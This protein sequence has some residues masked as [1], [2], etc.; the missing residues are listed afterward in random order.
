MSAKPTFYIMNEFLLPTPYNHR[1]FVEKFAR[2]FLYNG[3]NIK[4]VNNISRLDSPGFVMISNHPFYHR[5]ATRLYYSSSLSRVS[6]HQMSSFEDKFKATILL[7]H[8][9]IR[10]LAKRIRD[11]KIVLLAWLRYKE[12]DFFNDLGI[13]I[14]FT[15]EHHYGRPMHNRVIAWYDY[16]STKKNALPVEFAADVDPLQ[17]G[18]NCSNIKYVISYVGNR[19]YSPEYYSMFI[20]RDDCR[21]VPT[22]PFI[23]ERDRIAIYRNSRGFLGLSANYNMVNQ[24][25]TERIFESLAYGSI[26]LTDNPYAVTATD[27]CAILIRDKWHLTELANKLEARGEF[28]GLRARGFE[29]VKKNGTYAARANGFINLANRLFGMS[30]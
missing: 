30:F 10:S 17:V 4:V 23:Q 15:G 6:D 12:D 8:A 21:I 9:R 5:Y 29:F 26:C 25:V 19:T 18:K 13:P 11:K 27:G 28:E 2:G 24:V 20:G 22:P 1:F 3:F 14:I 7:E 16:Y